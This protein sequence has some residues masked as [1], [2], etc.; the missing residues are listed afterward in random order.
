MNRL[1]EL[2][3][4]HGLTLRELHQ[5]VNI[6]YSQL[7]RIEKGKSALYDDHI[8]ALTTYFCVTA[9]YLLGLSDDPTPRNPIYYKRV[10]FTEKITLAELLEKYSGI[11]I[12]INYQQDEIIIIENPLSIDRKIILYK[13]A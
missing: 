8:Q 5:I 10:E 6:N 11:E 2:R 13:K 12:I 1:K 7:G 3:T 4:K 9:D